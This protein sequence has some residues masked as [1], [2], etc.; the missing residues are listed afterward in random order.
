MSR[1]G[2]RMAQTADRTPPTTVF[3][4]LAHAHAIAERRILSEP[5][6]LPASDVALGIA[7]LREQARQLECDHTPTEPP[8]PALGL[9]ESLERAERLTRDGHFTDPDSARSSEFVIAL[10]DL[11]REARFLA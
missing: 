8:E 9:V 2:K 11:I 3:A 1:E 7:L 4:L 10:C 6:N 5:L